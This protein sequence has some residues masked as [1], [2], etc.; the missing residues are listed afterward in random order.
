MVANELLLSTLMQHYCCGWILF[1]LLL[2]VALQS[3]QCFY[4][5]QMRKLKLRNQPKSTKQYEKNLD[6]PDFKS[7]SYVT[8]FNYMTKVKANK[9]NLHSQES[10]VPKLEK[11]KFHQ[12]LIKIIHFIII[13]SL[14]S[15]YCVTTTLIFSS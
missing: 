4:V 13:L 8:N 1:N 7:F 2:M 15:A 6:L 5:L 3:R 14:Q 9:K 11:L 12:M 10:C